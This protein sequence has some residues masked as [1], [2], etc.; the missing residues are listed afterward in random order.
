[1]SFDVTPPPPPKKS[2]FK[3]AVT[4]ANRTFWLAL[5]AGAGSF[6]YKD[7]NPGPQ[8]PHEAGKK[9]IVVL[10]SGWGA[11]AFLNALDTTEYNVTVISPRN[12]FLFTPLLPSVAVG[13]LSTRSILQPTRYVTRH[14]T[15]NVKVIEAEAQSVDVANKT[16]S[17][18]D[19]S[20]IQG[21]V[22]ST[23]LPYDYLV[24]AVG[25][26]TQTFGIP[27]VQEHACF[28]KELNDA[29]KFQRRFLD[30]LESAAFPGQSEEEIDRL[31][32]MVV[33]GGGPTGVELSGE[34]HDFLEEDLKSWYPELA[35]RIKITLVEALPS[36]LPMFSKRLIDYTM[37]T[38]KES[39]IDIMTQTMVKEIKER[40]V[41]LAMPDKSIS[42]MPCGMVVWAAGNRNRK[43]TQDLMAQ[44]PADQTNKRGITIDESMQMKGTN[45]SIFALGDC[46]ASSHAPT[47]Q[48]ASQQGAYLAR[49]FAQRAKRD[50]LQTQV[51]DLENT[52]AMTLHDDTQKQV[53]EEAESARRALA[54]FKIRPFTY[55]HQGTLAYIGSDKAIADLPLLNGS[56]ASGGVLTYYFWRSAYLS[57]LFS[58]RNRTLVATDWVRT[59]IFG[60]FYALFATL[61]I[62]TTSAAEHA[63]QW[64]R[65]SHHAIARSQ[66]QV[67]VAVHSPRQN[68]RKKCRAPSNP[69][70]VG[71]AS[72][73][74][75]LV[76]PT[77]LS[78]RPTL[79]KSTKHTTKTS[80]SLES[81]H[82]GSSSG[83]GGSGGGGGAL[84]LNAL[85][86]IGTGSK[87]WT[88]S[89]KSSNA[90]SLSDSTLN[91]TKL[92]SALSHTFMKAPD[93]KT[94]MRAIYPEGSWTYN[95]SP[96]GGLSFYAP[97]PRQL[98]V[99]TAKEL[100]FGYSVFF[101][102]GFEFNMGGKLPGLY[103]GNSAEDSVSC[104]GG[105][106]STACY[107]ARL[108]W[109][110]DGMGEV[111]T[112]LPDYEVGG[113][114][115]NKAVCNVAPFSE[116]NPTYGAS[117]GRGSF[118][119]AT[120]AWTT[121]S[122]RVRLNDVGKANGEI[123]LWVNGKSVVNVNGLILRDSSAGRHRGIQMQTFFGGSTSDWASPKTQ[124]AYFSD[125]SM[126]ITETL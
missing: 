78:A 112:Y 15:R 104:S 22:S 65:R 54:K 4:I 62:I 3:S 37:S 110:T 50:A 60:R 28:M 45:G 53:K 7:R 1:M 14:K 5:L 115:A 117:V 103:G 86:P 16:V 13:T 74:D 57:T 94:A 106:R 18:I 70:S 91:P 20:D 23:T 113:F 108:M 29:E 61:L 48:V 32:H 33:V 89:P 69:G 73:T 118:H 122:Q 98:D 88:T 27:G 92:L 59:K 124:D 114:S 6:Y 75:V 93:G 17:F 35:G 123:Q 96:Q 109:R 101:Q 38:F 125:F 90:M 95:H 68:T 111:Y 67:G 30:C 41:T 55:S 100:T 119:F 2:R 42:E 39:K 21:S 44:L 80:T 8:L 126:A 49:A 87:S 79:T 120:G 9:N 11:T 105:R 47:A 25:A 84:S 12:Y 34:L 56:L 116:C 19:N 121:V 40:S 58:L 83:S 82:S 77:S 63:H 31:L 51:T 66:V 97:G 85:F 99:T 107:S 81:S 26:E 71:L 102:D 76:T 46:T 36:V 72:G 10:G 24:Y 43:I 52:L 64:S